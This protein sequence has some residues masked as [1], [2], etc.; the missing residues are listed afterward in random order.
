MQDAHLAVPSMAEGTS[1][2]AVFDGHGGPEVSVFVAER[3]LRV[4][5]DTEEWKNGKPAASRTKHK[6]HTPPRLGCCSFCHS[7]DL[8][9]LFRVGSV[10][11][12]RYFRSTGLDT[13]IYRLFSPLPFLL[14]FLFLFLSLSITDRPGFIAHPPLTN[15][16]H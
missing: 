7:P 10:G 1:C 3:L 16:H 13:C 12:C 4:L 6:N 5:C 8:L 15:N 11:E 2:F 14:R 9:P